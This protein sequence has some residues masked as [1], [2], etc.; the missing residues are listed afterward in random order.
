M[1]KKLWIPIAAVCLLL[2]ILFLPIPQTSADDG[3][4]REYVALTY[5][6][7]AWN[8]ITEDGVYE[9]TRVY[10]GPEKNTPMEELW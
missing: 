2:A 10:W 1:K 5:K 7:V 3:G 6:I 8:R 4:S 9:A